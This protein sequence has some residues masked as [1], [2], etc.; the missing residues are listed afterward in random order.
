M[1]PASIKELKQELSYRSQEDLLT[2]CLRLS[3]F[4]KE[5]KEL[6]TYLLFESSDESAY[7]E[8]VKQEVDLQFDEI[9]T[10]NY[11]FIKKSVRKILRNLKKFIRYS[12]KKETEI[13][14]LIQFCSRLKSFSPPIEK[15]KTLHNI[16]Q[17]ELAFIHRKVPS[18]HED[19]QHDYELEL[20]NLGAGNGS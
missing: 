19:L 14:L 16:Y 10:R 1:K 13:E 6:L 11:Y 18:L 15:N 2:I 4:K 12:G 20:Q 3:K 5:N 7:V 17:R 9:N 8:R